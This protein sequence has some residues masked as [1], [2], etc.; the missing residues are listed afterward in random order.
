MNRRQ[1]QLPVLGMS[2]A[3]CALRLERTLRSEV[4]GVEDA[5]VNLA[6]ETATV[7]YDA[8]RADLPALAAAVARAGFR[9][10]L[11]RPDRTTDDEERTARAAD[12]RRERRAF[13][14]GLACTVPLVLLGM[15]RDLDLLGPW[16]HA[17]WVAWL[18]GI[19]ATPVQFYT[20]LAFYRGAL[21]AL[22]HRS[23]DMNVL[24]ALGSTTAFAF[25][26]AVLLL[27]GLGHHVYFET[28]AAIVTLIR[29]GK[30]LE[31]SARRRASDA[32]RKLLELTP[33]VAHLR[34]R[35][36]VERDVPPDVLRPGD[37]V[38]VRPGERIPVDG[39]VEEGEAGVDRSML[40]G[41]ATP[42]HRAP[43][44]A[45]HGG[46][47]DLDGRLLVRATAVGP[48]ST[49][50]RIV[51]LVRRAQ[52]TKAPI[53]RLADRVSAW[54]VPAI[55]AVA[56]ATFILWWTLGG[57]LAPALLRLVAVLVVACPCALGLATPMAIVTGTA[58]AARLGIL[59]RDGAALETLRHVTV[60][61][62]DKT[63]TLTRGRPALTDWIPAGDAP[64][65]ALLLAGALDTA[66]EHPAARA[67]AAAARERHGALPEPANVRAAPGRGV[68]GLVA[69]R[70][71]RVGSLAWLAAS[72][73]P[74]PPPLDRRAAELA[75]TGRTV[76]GVVIE[77]RWAGL[78]ALADEPKPG[79]APAVRALRAQGLRVR[80]LSG[81][82]AAAARAAARAL[83]IEDVHA[84]VLPQDKERVLREARERGERTAMVGDG[85]NDAPALAAADVGIAVGGGTEAA[86]EAAGVSLAGDDPLGVPRAVALSRATWNVI[87]QNLF[88]AFAYNVTLIP[89]AAGAL[90]GLTA[91]PPA[92]RDFHPALAAAAMALSSLTVVL[93]SLRLG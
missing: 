48:D 45:V 82:T 18:L 79:A 16:S 81:D 31:A 73:T 93:N 19:L 35:P 23:A 83:D 53:Q 70:T 39:V 11:P 56:A 43:G 90:H 5:A 28:S 57:S 67:I 63:G 68:E 14:V 86:A 88:W 92:L 4:P 51:A 75:A 37:L 2:C 77:D 74:P 13:A 9:A 60:V 89:A 46:T 47:V 59:F 58:A 21:A 91:L 36:G 38:A 69:G 30:L 62:F 84:E 65:D 1:V 52:A 27:P 20:G 24:V 12:L 61:F 50:A 33:A 72:T 41:E 3:N 71:V 78:A 17:P 26:W 42:V 8:D 6:S 64:G 49:L 34:L 80:L 7:V 29:L 76:A 44:D 54:F 66:S 22:R 32:I 55:V 85:L 87:R 15:G 25:S 10:V 40:T